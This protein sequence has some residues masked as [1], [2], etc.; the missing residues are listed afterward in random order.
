M[1]RLRDDPAMR[2]FRQVVVCLVA[3]LIALAGSA[4]A[5]GGGTIRLGALFPLQGDTAAL[6][7]QEYQGVTIARDLANADGGVGGRRIALDTRSVNTGADVAPAVASLAS[8]GVPAIIGTYSSQLSIPAS[9]ASATRGITYW[10]AGAVADQV[11]GRGYDNVFRVGATGANLGNNSANFA[12]TEIAPRLSKPASAVR[13]AVIYQNDPYGESVAAAALTTARAAAMPIVDVAT[14][15]AYYPDWP[16]VIS[17]LQAAHPDVIILASYILDGVGFR[18]AMLAAGLH[19]GALIGSTMAE[20]YPDFGNLLGAD[21]VGVFA[22]DR[23]TWGFNE[24]VLSPE[25]KALYLRFEAV[26]KAQNGGTEPTEEAMAGFTAAWALF[27]DVLP[28]AAHLDSAGINAAARS[29][30]LPS[31]S[32]PNG[33]GLLFAQDSAHLGQ[34]SRAVAVIWQWQGIRNRVTVW[35]PAYAVG[36][37]TMVPLPR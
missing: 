18:R 30:D 34:N 1:G 23:P 26:W 17:G 19:V 29:V 2:R 9:A 28:K 21:A 37:V 13:V 33:A 15:N 35:P 27:H 16:T 31:G 4:S 5:A 32:L 36:T 22:S 8:D 24:D 3:A 6:A 12:A 14:Y 20:C 11:T 7:E 25:A 10:E